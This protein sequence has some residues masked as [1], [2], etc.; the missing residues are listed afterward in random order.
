MKKWTL[1]IIGIASLLLLLNLLAWAVAGRGTTILLAVKSFDSAGAVASG[2]TLYVF[3]GLV[4]EIEQNKQIGA[5]NVE[6]QHRFVHHLKDEA[7]VA[8][9][10]LHPGVFEISDS[11]PIKYADNEAAFFASVE[12]SLPM[13]TMVQTILYAPG[14]VVTHEK[15]GIWFF[16]WWVVRDKLDS[17]S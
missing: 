13:Y 12:R 5:F 4:S 3:T 6:V 11:R 14:F 15:T 17:I 8:E 9:V 2:D 1:R 7:T 16:G 10:R